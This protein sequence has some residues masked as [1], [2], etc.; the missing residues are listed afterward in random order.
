MEK[1]GK[2]C[3]DMFYRK[4]EKRLYEYYNNVDARKN[5][6][7]WKFDVLGHD[8]DS[9]VTEPTCEEQGYTTHTC[10][11]C[12]D[13]YVDS[14]VEASGHTES[15]WIIDQEATHDHEG[16]KHTECVTCGKTIKNEIIEKIEK[17]SSL[18]LIVGLGSA[19][20]ISIIGVILFI[21]FKR[22]RLA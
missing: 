9:V 10:S 7:A 18:G 5:Y 3:F 22:K 17:K 6:S 4:I 2:V 20:G 11:R 14:Y 8:Y 12:E 15:D 16:H 19:G 21:I 1:P 13:S